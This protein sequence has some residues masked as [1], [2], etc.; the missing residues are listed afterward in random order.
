[1][2]ENSNG[3][4]VIDYHGGTFLL[5]GGWVLSTSSAAPR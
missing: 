5:L 4:A 2:T 3:H 1:M